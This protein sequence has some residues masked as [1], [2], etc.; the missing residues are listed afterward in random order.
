VIH[1][2]QFHLRH[3]ITDPYVSFID[4]AVASSNLGAQRRPKH[5]AKT[6]L[7]LVV[8]SETGIDG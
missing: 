3:S 2:V 5:H 4:S 1:T 8:L 7:V 6:R